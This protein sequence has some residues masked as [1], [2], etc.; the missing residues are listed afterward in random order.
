MLA[1][2]IIVFRETLEAALIVSI[3]L[4]ASLGIVGRG[5]WVAAGVAGGAAGAGLVALFAAGISGMFSGN[6]QELL[7]ASVLLLAACMLA[8]HN[9]WIAHHCQGGHGGGARPGQG[10][11]DRRAPARRIGTDHGRR[12]A[13]RKIRNG[14]VRLWRRGRVARE[15]LGDAGWRSF[16]AGRWRRIGCGSLRRPVAIPVRRLFAVTSWMVLLLAAGLASQAV[17]FLV[18][19]DM[20]PSLGN[21]VWDTSFLLSDGSI[22]GRV[23][24]TLIGYVAR[25]QGIQ[26]LVFGLT[27]LVIGIP[28]WLI[29]HP[30]HHVLGTAV[31]VVAATLGV[32]HQAAADLKVRVPQ[33][34]YLELELEHNGLV[35]FG[36]RGS[37][38]DRAQSYT[39][40]IEYG[41][42]PWWKI[43]IEGELASGG[44]QHLTWEATTLENIFQLTEPGEYA[45]NLGFFAEYA[46]ATGRAPNEITL[47]PIVQKELPDFLNLDTVHTLNLF[48]SRE[49]GGNASRATALTTAWQS[50]ARF[51]SWFAPGVEYYGLIED[52][53]HAGRYNQQQHLLGP[54]LTGSHSLAPYGRLKYE[55]GYLFGLTAASPTGAVRWRLEYEVV[56]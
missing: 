20:L 18:Q 9:I 29:S 34:D 44:G 17:S 4:A 1:I 30:R 3:V 54:V 26:L 28:M 16:E 47:G 23:L 13:A 43:G 46:Q 33:V 6:G 8:W 12:S 52:L 21:D 5:R 42:L 50:V 32:P 38:F 14:A 19:A 48:F 56:F 36:R 22:P 15:F 53:G 24:H 40:E 25:P 37:S 45:F 7:N 10:G 51:K 31:V 11:R 55:V 35:T 39:N 2:A 27:I 41:L 49:V